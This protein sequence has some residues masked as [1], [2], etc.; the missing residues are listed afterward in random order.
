MVMRVMP[1]PLVEVIELRP[2]MV[3]NWRSS[4]VATEDA[5]V[6][7]L[8]PGS[9]A[10]DDD[11]REIDVRERRH[12]QQAVAE[13]AE[14]D[15]GQ[16]QQRRHDRTTDAEFRQRHDGLPGLLWRVGRMD[17][18]AAAIGE[19]ELTVRHDLLARLETLGDHALAGDGPA[20]RRPG[21]SRRCCPP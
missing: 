16:H 17:F 4:G 13:H 5:I 14:N 7:G 21:A 18:D 19:P 3:E 15:E 10:D 8:A 6:S 20:H 9:V 11:G 2:A 12:R 1:W